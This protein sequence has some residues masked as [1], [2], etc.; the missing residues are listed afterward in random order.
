V[1]NLINGGS[2]NP[3][4]ASFMFTSS[5]GVF[6]FDSAGKLF[7]SR[8]FSKAESGKYEAELKAGKW[9]PPE[10]ELIGEVEIFLGFKEAKKGVK[11]SQD[12]TKLQI[13]TNELATAKLI[14]ANRLISTQS[15]AGSYSEDVVIIQLVRT[16]DEIEH[17][18]NMLVMR[19]RDF[20][21]L[22]SPAAAA[23]S[24]GPEGLSRLLSGQGEA[25]GYAIPKEHVAVFAKL[26]SK[27]KVLVQQQVE[28]E[29]HLEA[30][31]KH[32]CPNI[33]GLAGT[34]I[35]ARLIGLAGS[36][37]RLARMPYSTLQL[38]GAEKA[39]FRHVRKGSKTPK[40][41][42]IFSHPAVSGAKARGKA[43]RMLA[44]RLTKAARL[45]YFHGPDMSA[46]LAEDLERRLK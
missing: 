4:M 26:A 15:F 24:I 25:F 16:H 6:V 18:L 27:L 14:Q 30:T 8:L 46:A 21:K 22:F 28:L 9:I 35:G 13:A 39:M 11:L 10:L 43:A 5:L 41:G 37:A 33:L 45:D 20:A 19:V 44:E 42:I 1:K 31:M 3:K 34:L 12:I 23:E 32:I 36:L 40:H 29:G 17:V 7:K 2:L 38:L